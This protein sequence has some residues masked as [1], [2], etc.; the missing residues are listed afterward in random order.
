MPNLFQK[1][2]Q[3]ITHGHSSASADEKKQQQQ[4]SS[5][6][7]PNASSNIN[8]SKSTEQ[9]SHP[10]L[11]KKNSGEHNKKPDLQTIFSINIP[12]SENKSKT[13]KSSS[14]QSNLP[15]KSAN[16]ATPAQTSKSIFSLIIDSSFLT[17]EQNKSGAHAAENIF[18]PEPAGEETDTFHHDTVS[19]FK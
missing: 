19:Y 12:H 2:K 5:N 11:A 14:G 17:D 4:Q 3:S 6:Q 16:E 8:Q 7:A 13:S 9:A 10:N 15:K 1:F 18:D